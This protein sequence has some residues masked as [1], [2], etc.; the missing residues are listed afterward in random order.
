MNLFEPYMSWRA[1][2]YALKVLMGRQLAEGPMVKKFELA[3]A[4]KFHLQPW[5]CIA[6]NSGTSALELAYELAGVGRGDR[7]ITPILTCTATN[8][9]ILHRGAVPVFADITNDYL[10][11]PEDIKRKITKKTKAIVYVDFGGA[12]HSVGAV[13]KIARNMGLPLIQDSAQ[14]V[15]PFFNPKGDFVCVSFQAIKTLTC[16]DGG[17]L[18]VK[19]TG[20]AR[21]AR[22]LRWFG[23]DREEKQRVGDTDLTMAGY[24]YQMNDIVAAIGLGNLESLQNSLDQ[25]EIVAR[26][27]AESGLPIKTYPWLMILTSPLAFIIKDY[28][29]KKGIETGQHHYRNDKY[30]IFGGKIEGLPNMDKLEYQYLLLPYH[31]GMGEDDAKYVVREIKK[32]Y[33]NF[34]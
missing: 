19:D 16:G 7:V 18:I 34:G 5:Q 29:A 9:P 30:T 31:Q 14:S 21:N 28:L 4:R 32:F 11:D 12:S 22:K 20:D 15:G 13:A 26:V 10:V 8:L 3:F 33:E 6:V 17:M 25:R 1:R 24:K 27:Y 2:W 23:Y